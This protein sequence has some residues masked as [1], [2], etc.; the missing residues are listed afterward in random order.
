MGL[1]INWEYKTLT[2]EAAGFWSG[3]GKLDAQLLTGQLNELGSEGW[4]LVSIFDTTKHEGQ[5]RHVYA[6]LKRVI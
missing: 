3:G 5:T 2:F 4:E 1:R 6:V